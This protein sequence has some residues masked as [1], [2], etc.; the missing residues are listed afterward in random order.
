MVVVMKQDAT[1]SD[2]ELV[3]EKV[4]NAG[5]EAFVS[6]GA[7]HTVVGLV[8][9][10]ARFQAIPFTQLRGVDH[11]IQIGKPYKMVARDLHPESHHGE[12]GFDA[13]GPRTRSRSSRGRARWSPRNRR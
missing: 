3:C 4:R 5:G 10:T 9:D 6:R 11:V 13:R 8:G 12:R 2:I 7:V 1:D